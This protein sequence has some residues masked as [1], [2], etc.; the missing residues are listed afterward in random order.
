MIEDTAE[1]FVWKNINPD[2]I[3]VLDK[4]ILSRKL[5]YIYRNYPDIH[6]R[7]GEYVK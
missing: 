7:I 3:W 4:L 2:D 5:G 6:G 1:D